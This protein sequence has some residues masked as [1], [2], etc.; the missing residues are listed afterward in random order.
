MQ[1][2]TIG[3]LLAKENITIQHGNYHTAWFDIKNRTLGL[4]QWADNGKDVYDLL[5]GHEVGHALFTPYEGWHDS[6]E[7]LEGCP[8]SYINVIED[9]RIEKLVRRAYPGLVG[10]F[11]RGYKKL[12]EDEFFGDIEG[13]DMDQIKLIDKI[14]LK[15]KLGK[16]IDVTF[17]AEELVLFNRAMHT[18]T[19][20]QVVDLVK[21]VLAYTK[22]N[23]PELLEQP[24]APTFEDQCNEEYGDN[25]PDLPKGHDDGEPQEGTKSDE[26]KTENAP[27]GQD[28]GESDLDKSDDKVEEGDSKKSQ[29]TSANPAHNT[30][31]DQ[32]ITDTIFRDK[33]AGLVESNSHGEE[34]LYCSGISKAL[35]NIVVIDHKTLAADRLTRSEKNDDRTLAKHDAEFK[36]YMKDTRK[37]TNFAIKE[38]EMRKAAHQWQRASTAKSGS[39]DVNKVHGYKFNE[40]IFARVTSLADAKNHGMI[41]IVDYSG[42]MSD[43]MPQV[44]DQL[45]HLVVFCKAV[46]IPF[47][48]YAFTTGN[49]RMIRMQRDDVTNQADI[50]I[51]IDHN[52]KVDVVHKMYKDASLSCDE[53]SMPLL[54]SSS[55]KKAEYT[56]AMANLFSKHKNDNWFEGFTSKFEQWGSTPLN[57]A[58]V[59]SHELVKKFKIKHNVEK[60]NFVCL[61][62]GDTN[63]MHVYQDRKLQEYKSQ[64]EYGYAKGMNITVD[65]KNL[66]LT[67]NGKSATKDLLNNIQKRYGVNTIGFF[68]ADDN[69]HFYNRI[70]SA[71]KDSSTNTF[72]DYYSN[73]WTELKKEANTEYRKNKCVIRENV[74][75]YNEYYIIKGGSQLTAQGE[76]AMEGMSSQNNSTA[77]IRN[78]FKKQSKSKKTNKVLLTRFGKAV[79]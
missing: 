40:D 23:Q 52:K 79:A 27:E 64:T 61:S 19:F 71:V 28:D 34:K 11:L 6:E 2:K 4:P 74:L 33:E 51:I 9:A 12:S 69:R 73:E 8:R 66:L 1:N 57:A 36:Q 10:P 17:N 53:L 58:L 67:D 26:S 38:F 63:A 54:V 16:A 47:E 37:N 70:Q 13:I 45:M 39:L 42:S 5:I 77:Q 14:N 20:A 41:M 18:E 49:P 29:T 35:A 48:V 7:A 3:K 46:N 44:L 56:V 72:I 30:E 68:M 65:N 21:D 59:V 50:D 75:G 24:E 76:D 31:E 15:A 22:E 78:A 25:M 62:D 43:S 55:L 32:S 60:M